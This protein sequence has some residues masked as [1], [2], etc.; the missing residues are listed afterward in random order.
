MNA[1]GSKLWPTTLT[2][3]AEGTSMATVSETIPGLARERALALYREM[4]VIRRTEEALA[5]AHAA[6]WFTAP[7]TPTS[8]RKRSR[9]ACPPISGRTT[10][11]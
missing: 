2:G 7:V 8:A 6:G 1:G 5:R 4:V 3:V 10:R 9:W 11:C